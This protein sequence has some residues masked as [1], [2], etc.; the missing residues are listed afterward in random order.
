MTRNT[1]TVRISKKIHDEAMK[2]KE[3]KMNYANKSSWLSYLI[4][5]G[6]EKLEED[7]E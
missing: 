4:K 3:D 2:F 6:M 7:G 1:T 5:R